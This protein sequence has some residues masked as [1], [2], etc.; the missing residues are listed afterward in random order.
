MR[1]WVIRGEFFLLPKEIA[2]VDKPAEDQSVTALKGLIKKPENPISVDSMNPLGATK[3]D[4][5]SG[6]EN[7]DIPLRYRDRRSPGA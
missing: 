1:G 2:S 6:W 3:Q 5:L 4:R 7:A